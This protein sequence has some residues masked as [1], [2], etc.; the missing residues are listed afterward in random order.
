[1]TSTG[2]P[3][4]WALRI[5]SAV[6][7][8]APSQKNT[9]ASA[10][11][12]IAPFRMCPAPRPCRRQSGK[13]RSTAKPRSFAYR[14]PRRSAPLAPPERITASDRPARTRSSVAAKIA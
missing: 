14:S 9:A 4:A 13:W 11:A 2:M 7:L 3:R 5:P 6:P 10:A 8:L 1:M 12:T